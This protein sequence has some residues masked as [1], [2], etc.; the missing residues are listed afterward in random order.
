MG[1]GIAAAPASMS[2]I[3]LNLAGEQETHG[4]AADGSRPYPLPSHL[5]MGQD[6]AAWRRRPA[7][8]RGLAMT[9]AC[10]ARAR[11]AIYSN[12]QANSDTTLARLRSSTL[13]NNR[14]VISRSKMQSYLQC[15]YRLMQL[16]SCWQ[17]INIYEIQII[18][19]RYL[20]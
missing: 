12:A 6:Q 20:A 18:I 1:G 8:R 2:R 14:N 3:Q 15:L 4:A 9:Q 5:A 10:S 11:P 19:T 13:H 7:A 16:S 17:R